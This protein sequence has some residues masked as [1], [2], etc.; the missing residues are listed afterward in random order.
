MPE[1]IYPDKERILIG[2]SSCLLGEEV[3][4]DKSHKHHSYITKT[5]GQFFTF[6]PFCPEMAIGLGTP[7][8]TLRLVDQSGEIHCVGNKTEGHNVT[9]A[10]KESANDQASW[11]AE[12]CGYILK[13]GSP[14]CGM[15]RVKVYSA[16]TRMPLFSD[17]GIY[18]AQLMKNFPLLPVEEEGRLGDPVLRE[19]FIQRVFAYRHW[20]DIENEGLSMRV[21]TEF[22][23]AY[24]YVLLSHDQDRTRTLGHRLAHAS[25]EPIQEVA[26]WYLEEWMAILTIRATRKNHVNVLQHLQGF[27]KAD[28]DKEDKAELTET[29]TRY[30]EGL[31]P[32]IVPITLLRHHFRRH[33]KPFTTRS[34]YLEPHP[35]EL[36]LLNTI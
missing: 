25:K 29:I 27:L 22:H 15:E 10:L 1:V 36:M 7:R 12:L 28:L 6:R 5:L 3:R 35:A 20:R 11:H 17:S 9:L 21:L 19:N 32:L 4:F 18:A 30:R 26:Q 34:K 16:E 2:T 33:P 24:K 8:E 23:S 14:S 13:K 31:L